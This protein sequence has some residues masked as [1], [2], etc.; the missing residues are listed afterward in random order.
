[1]HILA[2]VPALHLPSAQ[3]TFQ[4]HRRVAFGSNAWEFWRTRQTGA[5]TVWVVASSTG[6]PKDGI[7]GIDPGKVIFRGTFDRMVDSLRGKHPNPNL[8][9]ASTDDD[10]AWAVFFEIVDL[11]RL[12][13]PLPVIQQITISGQKLARVPEGPLQIRDPEAL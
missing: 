7:L 5:A 6:F 11:V 3:A 10:G 12:T 1:M 4:Q 9:P 13:R 8:R 2:P